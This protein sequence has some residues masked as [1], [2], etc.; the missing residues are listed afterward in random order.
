MKKRHDNERR[1]PAAGKADKLARGLGWLSIG[2]GTFEL[3]ASSA[4]ARNLG[5]EDSKNLVRAYGIREIATGI[6]ILSASDPKPW[7]WGRVGGDALDLATLAA[8][9][10]SDNPQQNMVGMAMAGVAGIAALDAACA[11]ALSKAPDPVKLSV[12][13]YSDRRGMPKSPDAMRG[14][15]RNFRVPDDM[16]VPEALRPYAAS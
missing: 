15:A 6:G 4:V 5:A 14:I 3:A 9:W 7:I 11:Y 8:A 10:R 13:D 12:H 1:A 2:L 16:R